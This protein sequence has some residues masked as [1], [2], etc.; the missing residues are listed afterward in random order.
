MSPLAFDCA[1]NNALGQVLLQERVDDHNGQ[2][3]YNSQRHTDTG[4]GQGSHAAAHHRRSVATGKELDVVHHAHQ[5]VL[6]TVIYRVIH[7]VKGI[8]PV[9]PVSQAGEQANRHIDRYA[10]RYHDF[11]EGFQLTGSV[12]LGSFD[13]LKGD[14]VFVVVAYQHDVH[15]VHQQVGQ[16]QGKVGVLDVKNLGPHNV[17]GNNTAIEQHG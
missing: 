15:G 16:Q 14:A 6:N 17:A 3:T 10:Q 8:D 9:I 11:P 12:D 4:A 1:H 7:I 5:K 2:Y 13:Q